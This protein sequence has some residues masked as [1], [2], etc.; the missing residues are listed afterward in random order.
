MKSWDVSSKGLLKYLMAKN[1]KCE[2]VATAT[3]HLLGLL[4]S[5]WDASM[6]SVVRPELEDVQDLEIDNL[7]RR[8]ARHCVLHLRGRTELRSYQC[9]SRIINQGSRKIC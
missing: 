5:A 8:L 4:H 7:F 3:T 9:K 6:K 1:F 2:E